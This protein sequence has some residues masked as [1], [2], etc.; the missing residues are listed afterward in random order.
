M[1][2]PLALPHQLWQLRDIRRNPPRKAGRTC[3]MV[4]C[5][6]SDFL[7]GIIK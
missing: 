1:D 6:C 3:L 5:T 4:T 2:L 7:N